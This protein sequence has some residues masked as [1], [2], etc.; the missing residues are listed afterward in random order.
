MTE[1]DRDET[2]ERQ[3][4]SFG[5]MGTLSGFGGNEVAGEIDRQP[6]DRRIHEEVRTI[7]EGNAQ[8]PI[9]RFAVVVEH[10]VVTLRGVA[11]DEHARQRAED[12]VAMIAGV[13][14]VRNELTVSS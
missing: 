8:V 2:P 4:E 5:N 9:E 14:E 7:L 3:V 10:A 12:M 1:H 11:R 6:T 13:K